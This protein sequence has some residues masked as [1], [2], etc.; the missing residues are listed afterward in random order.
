V[1]ATLLEP[2]HYQDP[3]RLVMVCSTLRPEFQDGMKTALGGTALGCLG[4][5]WVGRSMQGMFPGVPSLDLA[6]FAAVAITLLLAA[7]LACY[8]PAR[9]A[10]AVD[11]LT[12]L[13]DE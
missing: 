3:D 4:A 2:L 9:R 11:P 12:A 5:Y 10:A 1:Y 13:R 8:V 6:T 7:V